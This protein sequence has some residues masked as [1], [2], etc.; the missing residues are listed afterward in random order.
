MRAFTI[1]YAGRS[2]ESFV[3]VLT[4]NHVVVIGDVR[5]Y[6]Q[7][8]YPEFAKASLE[9]RLPAF[10]IAYLHVTELGGFRGEYGEYVRS[11]AFERGAKKLM[12]L[13]E[14]KICCIMCLERDP[15]YCHRRFIV[16]YLEAKGV[17][18]T[19]L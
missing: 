1:G 9:K 17:K 16:V 6:P 14:R 13:M 19:H 12:A 18:V 10:G 2:F 11:E 7:S 8:K 5:R 3:T 4:L 15:A